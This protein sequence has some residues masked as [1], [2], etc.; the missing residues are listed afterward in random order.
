MI[1]RRE[2]LQALTTHARFLLALPFASLFSSCVGTPFAHTT[3]EP[4][5][6]E[7]MNQ[8]SFPGTLDPY[9]LPRHVV[10]IRYDLRL[11]PDLPAAT[12]S[13]QETITL[14]IHRPTA[15][16]VLNAIEIDIVSAQIEGGSGSTMQATITLDASLQR[17]HLTFTELLSPGTWR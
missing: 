2:I 8:D 12:F 10:P 4:S 13:G 16:I 15:D 7:D 9:R 6:G 14:T 17:C 5:K 11:E 3:T 1:S